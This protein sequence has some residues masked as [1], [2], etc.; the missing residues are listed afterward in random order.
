MKALR[1]LDYSQN[2]DGGKG[3]GS[4]HLHL[5]IVL[6]KEWMDR[7]TLLLYVRAGKDKVLIRVTH[8]IKMAKTWTQGCDLTLL[9]SVDLP[10]AFKQYFVLK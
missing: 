1:V 6:V 10:S 5:K 4:G 8:K 2:C 9:F 3:S 7:L